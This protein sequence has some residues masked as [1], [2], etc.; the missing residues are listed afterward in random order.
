MNRQAREKAGRRA[1]TLAVCYLRFKGYRI[2]DRRVKTPSGELDIIARTKS[3]LVIVE[4]KQRQTEKAAEDS[5]TYTARKRIMAAARLFVSHNPQYQKLG[6]RYDAV[7]IIGR[8]RV[9]H[10]PDLWREH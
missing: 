6:L 1:E 3:S 10:R 7:F 4:V 5:L 2:I 9:D 8:W